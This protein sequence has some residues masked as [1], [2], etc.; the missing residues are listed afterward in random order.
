MFRLG[1]GNCGSPQAA[2][3]PRHESLRAVIRRTDIT[4]HL[5][6]YR[7]AAHTRRRWYELGSARHERD[8]SHGKHGAP[9][10][11]VGHGAAETLIVVCIRLRF[12]PLIN[13]R[14]RIG[15]VQVA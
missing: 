14:Q 6:M 1:G 15:E 7:M 5:I 3:T 9:Y 10:N 4:S 12:F 11:S 8:C 2:L 13:G